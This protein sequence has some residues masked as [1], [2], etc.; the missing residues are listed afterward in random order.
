MLGSRMVR[1]PRPEGG[2]TDDGLLELIGDMHG[3][4]DIEEFR[5][6]LLH[7][8]RRA[9]SSDWISLNDIGTDPETMV[10]IVEPEIEPAMRDVFARYA[11]ENPLI[12]Y[13][14]RTQDGRVRRFSDITTPRR[15]HALTVYK[16]FYKPLGIEHQ[17]SFTLPHE[18]GRILGVALSRASSDFTDAE[19]EMLELARPFLIQAYRNAI[20]YTESQA[21]QV[22]VPPRGPDLDRLTGLGLT[23]RQAEVLQL[24]ATGASEQDIAAR[25]KI[26]HRTVQKHLELCYRELGVSSRS[27]AARI[28]WST[29]QPT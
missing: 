26:S 5:W 13:Y 4:L 12:E 16:E 19:C 23:R 11:H 6:E 15:L 1:L 9:V 10:G 25:L 24:V 27:H 7:A 29:S 8:V 17:L 22:V 20:L 14:I 28:A 21:T 2:P 18:P 3:L